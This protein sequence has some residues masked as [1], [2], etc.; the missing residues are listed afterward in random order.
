[1]DYKPQDL[2]L[3]AIDIFALFFPGAIAL[4]LRLG[5]IKNFLFKLL[6][7]TDVG[8]EF[9]SVFVIGAYLIGH[10]LVGT[11]VALNYVYEKSKNRSEKTDPLVQFAK[12]T[13]HLAENEKADRYLAIHR[14]FSFIRLNDPSVLAEIERQAANYKLFRSLAMIFLIDVVLS[15]ALQEWTRSIVSGC[16]FVMCVFRFWHL[17]STVESLILE[18][19]LLLMKRKTAKSTAT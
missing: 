1:M 12:K 11:G 2:F 3:S 17:K 15:W 6:D 19:Y 8:V 7:I 5:Y 18:F 14:A 9:W 16:A 10:I 13:I 4:F